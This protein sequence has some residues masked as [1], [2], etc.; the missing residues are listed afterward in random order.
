M[1]SSEHPVSANLSLDV[2]ESLQQPP[3]DLLSER[4]RQS[5]VN[6]LNIRYYPKHT[7][8]F[9]AGET[10]AGL[11]IIMKG[12]VEELSRDQQEVFSHYREEDLF[13]VSCVQAQGMLT[14][15]KHRFVALED[16]LVYEIPVR[17]LEEYAESVPE[18]IRF[19]SS[20]PIQKDDLSQAKH[21]KNLAE[22]ILTKVTAEICHPLVRVNHK[23]RLSEVLEHLLVDAS[24]C[25]LVE[26]GIAVQPSLITKTDV[27]MAL[28]AMSDRS[29]RVNL[30][31]AL[32]ATPVVD[33]GLLQTGPLISVECG[34]YLFDAML[35][36]TKHQIER[37]VVTDQTRIVGVLYQ[38][39]L[40]SLFSTHS[41]VLSLRIASAS[42]LVELQASAE[43]LKKLV[44]TL[45][46][47]G[48]KVQFLMNLVSTLN[49]MIIRKTFELIMPEAVVAHSALIVMGSE[50]R[51]EQI[52]PTD[53]DNALILRNGFEHPDLP[54]LLDSFSA[55]LAEFGYP[56][57]PGKVMVNNPYW[58]ASVSD[59]HQRLMTYAVLPS[60]AGLMEVAI[61]QDARFIVGDVSLFD[62]FKIN[63]ND[64]EKFSDAVLARY[65]ES[66]LVFSTPLTFW[67]QLK[68]SH[69][70]LD[71]KQGGLFPIVQG[72]R[73]L[74]LEHGI[75]AV[76]TLAR[77]DALVTKEVLEKTFARKL[78]HAF[79]LFIR[80]RLDQ[81][82]LQAANS[83]LDSVADNEINPAQLSATERDLLR[84]GL[85][86]VK[87]FKQ[88]LRHHFHLERL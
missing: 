17:V 27:L 37:V 60:D 52:M 62:E 83:F 12:V 45:F 6:R 11:M 72:V 70:R 68:S 76:S 82:L 77:I 35:L 1:N 80:F 39:Q 20:D 2:P 13:D 15:T 19:W 55:T 40:L 61:L 46:N 10:P 23:T 75:M 78:S 21:Q 51:G 48:I 67:G 57:C 7:V 44:A 79:C 8:I 66:A 24:G 63:F 41:H 34:D 22:F 32:M 47:N 25:L 4:Q 54:S 56:S 38:T 69:D 58:V 16:C 30:L 71:I 49:E 88:R 53:Q 36:M 84:Y 86:T 42:S 43:Q 26:S 29:D 85:H 74:S 64:K 14:Q 5:L 3:F 33:C 59:W 9:D 81:Q 28:Q 50:G 65:A 87:K 18:L 31:S 73:A